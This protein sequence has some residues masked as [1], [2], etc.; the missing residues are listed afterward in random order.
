[1]RVS[2]A[3]LLGLSIL[4][5]TAPATAQVELGDPCDIVPWQTVDNGIGAEPGVVREFAVRMSVPAACLRGGRTWVTRVRIGVTRLGSGAPDMPVR[6]ALRPPASPADGPPMPGG[7]RSQPASFTLVNVPIFPGQ[8]IFDL[9]PIPSNGNLND[10]LHG[11]DF[12]VSTDFDGDDTAGQFLVADQIGPQ[13]MACWTGVN[14]AVPADPCTNGNPNLSS[15]AFGAGVYTF[16]GRF[17]LTQETIQGREPLG[18]AWSGRYLGSPGTGGI[19]DLRLT[20]STIEEMSLGGDETICEFFS[21]PEDFS[22]ECEMTPDQLNALGEG[23]VRAEL[24][25]GG[26]TRTTRIIPADLFIFA[27]GFESGDTSVWNVTIQ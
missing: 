18:T 2:A 10:A 14:G 21:I 25:G 23:R 5:G 11:A 15:A 6:I 1:M 17:N 16:Y 9:D 12:F 24:S 8:G 4:A 3:L 22:F 20:R 7:P 26:P 13:D 19:S 27:D